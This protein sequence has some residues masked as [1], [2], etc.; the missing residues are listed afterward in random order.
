MH[1]PPVSDFPLFSKNFQTPWKIFKILPFPEKMSRFLYAKIS[2]DLFLLIYHKFRISPLYS[3]F[4]YIFSLFRENYYFPLLF[5]I[6]PCFR[7]IHL[8]FTYF[9]CISFPPTLTTMHLSITQCTCWTP[10]SLLLLLS[11][12]YVPYFNFENLDRFTYPCDEGM[13]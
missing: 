3:L 1:F 7:K 4:Q 5:K 8:L 12:M 13:S 11:Y 2:D 9:L 10:L 6:S